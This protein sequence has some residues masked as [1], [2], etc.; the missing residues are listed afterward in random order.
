[1]TTNQVFQSVKEHGWRRGLDNLLR[2][3]FGNWWKTNSWWVQSLI[4]V[5]V[6]NM[7]LANIVWGGD[8][9]APNAVGFY[10]LFA[11]LFPPIA[12]II[13]LQDAIVGEKETGTAAWVLSKPVSRS[14]FILSKLIALG[15]STIATMV[16]FP[17]IVAYIQMSLGAANWLAPL[18]F[19]GGLAVISLYQLFYLTLTLMLGTLFNHR[20]PVIGIP[21][22]L[23]FTQSMFVS[24][25]PVLEKLLPWSLIAPLDE[26]GVSIA[27]AIIHGTAIPQIAPIIA[28]LVMVVIFV[29]ISLWRF[30]QEEF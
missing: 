25:S 24:L 23:A 10:V 18:N 26:N 4:W 1:M 29:V 13:V 2:A 5:G 7:I 21:L 11:G 30:R 9:D 15:V 16:L 20:G 17:G 6:I 22:A 28:T 12:I 14:A 8:A 27:E 19:L 3:E